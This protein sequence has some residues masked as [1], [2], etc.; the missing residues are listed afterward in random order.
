VRRTQLWVSSAN[1][2]CGLLDV[3]SCWS[4]LD[5]QNNLWNVEIIAWWLDSAP[6]FNGWRCAASSLFSIFCGY[7][8]L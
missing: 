2:L 1:Q 7:H 6:D 4:D 5:K 3:G 8:F